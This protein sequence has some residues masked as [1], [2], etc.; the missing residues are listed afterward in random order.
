VDFVKVRTA[1]SPATYLAIAAAARRAGLPLAA[2]GDIVPPEDMLRAGQASV[3]HAIY[4]PLQKRSAPVRAH[5]LGELA[6]AGMA[7]VPTMVDYYQWLLVSPSDARRIIEDTLGRLDPRRRYVSGYLLEDWR[8]QVAERG[9]VRDALIRHLYLPRVYRGV[10]RDLQEMH[11]AG[12]RILPGTD[13][14]VALIYP[15]FSLRDELGYFVDKIGMTPMEALVSATRFA[16]EFSGMLDSLGTIEVGK[17]ADLVL[18][19]A[20]PLVDV[21]NVRRVHAVIARGELF[22][23]AALSSLLAAATR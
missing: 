3:E 22:D 10:L 2:H 17:L 15:G 19:D 7:I 11:R 23:R 9:N 21:R 13:V 12:V 14:G 18:L 5:L 6:S 20:D 8:E 4:P 1:A 16:A